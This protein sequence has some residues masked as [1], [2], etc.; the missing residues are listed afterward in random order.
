[1]SRSSRL[2]PSPDAHRRWLTA[3]DDPICAD[4]ANQAADGR[5][6]GPEIVADIHP[7]APKDFKTDKCTCH[8]PIVRLAVKTGARLKSP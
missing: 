2:L 4:H 5:S 3:S 8:Q 7:A 1:M 6:A